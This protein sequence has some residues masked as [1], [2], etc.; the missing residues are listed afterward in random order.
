MERKSWSIIDL[1]MRVEDLLEKYRS[2]ETNPDAELITR[3]YNFAEAAHVGEPRRHVEG[4]FI[5]HPLA[6]AILLA[7]IRADKETLAAG[8]LHDVL[9]HT[10]LDKADLAAEFGEEIA[11]LVDGVTVIQRV[12]QKVGEKKR[13]EENLQ[14]LL[15]ATAKDPRVLLIRM[16]EEVDNLKNL[17][18]FPEIE[19]KTTLEKAFEIYSPL[20]NLLG[21]HIFKNRL[22]DLAFQWT[23]PK[24]FAEISQKIDEIAE[25]QG[26][27]ISDLGKKLKDELAK[28]G[29]VAEVS[30]RE[31]HAYG[32]YRKLP[33]YAERG[34]GVWD[35]VLGLRIITDKTEQCYQALD[36]VHKMGKPESELFD[37]YI[38][39][40]KPNGYQSLHTIIWVDS[41]PVEIQIRT[42]EMHKV[43]EFGLA[44]HAYYNEKRKSLITPK[45]KIRLLRNLV[46]WE[47]EKKLNLFADKTFVFTPKADAIELPKG[48]TPIDFAFAIHTDIGR[49]CSGAKVNGKMVSLDYQLQNGE[50]VEIITARGKKPSA[51]WLKFVKTD[52]ARSQIKKALR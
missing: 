18:T 22:E 25:K 51:D 10:D 13:T 34:K 29:I 5:K 8:L 45:E 19:Q 7:D 50:V 12:S 1:A 43:A 48:A 23:H 49:S 26:T 38:A 16:A 24:E 2:Y 33:R 17:E 40:P 41:I 31:K 36:V 9:E 6:V 30:G 35:D 47:K 27:L 32:V 28:N 3:A 37:D 14:K 21:V 46:G 39:H 44:A 15:L 52:L 4:E 20:A 11:S 42:K